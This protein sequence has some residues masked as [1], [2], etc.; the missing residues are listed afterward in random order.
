MAVFVLKI[1]AT[2]LA[3]MVTAGLAL[4]CATAVSAQDPGKKWPQVVGVGATP[5]T[6][7]AHHTDKYVQ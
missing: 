4:L 3:R 5:E 1:G 6:L 7:K 2:M